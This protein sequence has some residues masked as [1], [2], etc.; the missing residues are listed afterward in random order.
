MVCNWGSDHSL[1]DIRL[2]DDWV[3]ASFSRHE[4]LYYL[5]DSSLDGEGA[6]CCK[7]VCLLLTLSFSCILNGKNSG[8]AF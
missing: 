3:E 4:N 2:R 1:G 7:W 6:Q 8:S 5:R